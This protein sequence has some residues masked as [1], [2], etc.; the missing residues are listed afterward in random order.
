MATN[1]FDRGEE[2]MLWTYCWQPAVLCHNIRAFYGGKGE[3]IE[4]NAEDGVAPLP[5]AL[6]GGDSG[7]VEER[8]S[9]E[10]SPTLRR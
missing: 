10:A 5:L 9:A 4:S 6:L 1:L 2:G 7:N 3:F 8:K